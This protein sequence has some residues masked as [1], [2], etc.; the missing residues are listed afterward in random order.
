[1]VI[2]M[3]SDICCG[4]TA[5]ARTIAGISLVMLITV[6]G[7]LCCPHSPSSMKSTLS[8]IA[9]RTSSALFMG[10]C[11]DMFALVPVTPLPKADINCNA[12]SLSGT[13][14]P[15]VPDPA[16]RLCGTSGFAF[17]TMVS[18]PG[19]N[20]SASICACSLKSVTSEYAC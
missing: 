16:F 5:P 11:A 10:G 9:C 12:V 6:D 17:K 2:P 14:T 8:P 1:M 4:D 3:A 15:T 13:L 7:T 20:R 19:Q 18:G